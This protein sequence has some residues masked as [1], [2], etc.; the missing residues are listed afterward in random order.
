MRS[1]SLALVL[2]AGCGAPPT[3]EPTRP[4][5]RIHGADETTLDLLPALAEVHERTVGTIAFE[6]EN[7]ESGAAMRALLA[8]EIELAASSRGHTP[9]EEEQARVNGFSLGG[10]GSRHVVAVDVVAV[11][12]HP[13]N[14]AGSLT[15]DQMIGVF[16]T[17]TIDD[18]SFLGQDPLRIR[19]VAPPEDT[20]S[21]ILFED[22]FC[23][24]RGLHRNV[25]TLDLDTLAD[26]LAADAGA[27]GF[28]SMARE[29]GKVI[30]LRPDPRGPALLPS[31]QNIIRGSY[32]LYHDELLYSAG[33]PDGAAA[34]FLVWIA[35]PA[36]QE[37]VDEARY[38]PLFLRPERLD[39]P[40]P[41]RETIH[42]ETGTSELTLRSRARLQMLTEELKER[43]G[44]AHHVVLEGFADSHEP[45]A[46]PLSE[47]RAAA[48]RDLLAAELPGVYF[49]L[50][51]RG[52]ERPI[53]PNE[54]PYGRERNRRVQVYLADEEAPDAEPAAPAAEPLA[55]P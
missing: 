8:G 33:P 17:G 37:V 9:A 1:L 40:R 30:G 27:V 25:E 53:A 43:V 14:L 39:D 5:L 52:A 13:S 10:E 35:S 4:T 24:P 26:V 12:V 46:V 32:P 50:I 34:E 51:P 29:V 15:Y 48:V 21:R 54:T 45:D 36:G 7:A 20:G 3:T 44:A 6:I 42:F 11:S 2:A 28:G 49:E 38:V 31:Q 55:E 16:C 41:L 47:E 18:W 19:P 23:G 22:F